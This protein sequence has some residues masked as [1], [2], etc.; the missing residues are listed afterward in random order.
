[1]ACI[2]MPSLLYLNNRNKARHSNAVTKTTTACSAL[3]INPPHWKVWSLYGTAK[4]WVSVPMPGIM[5]TK[6]RKT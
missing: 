5:V 6:P 1:M 3:I 2:A 4:T